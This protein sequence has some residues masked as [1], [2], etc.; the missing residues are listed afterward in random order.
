MARALDGT[1]SVLTESPVAALLV[2]DA[3]DALPYRV[4]GRDM[5]VALASRCGPGQERPTLQHT[6]C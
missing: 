1:S 6:V 3:I 5:D 4:P 2:P